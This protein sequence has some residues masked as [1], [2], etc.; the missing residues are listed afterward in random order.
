MPDPLVQLRQG[1]GGVINI[2]HDVDGLPITG[3][4]AAKYQLRDRE[5]NVVLTLTNSAGITW[6]DG[7]IVITITKDQCKTLAGIY[8]HEC[9]AV[10]L[11]G[12]DLTVLEGPI[13]F[14]PRKTWSEL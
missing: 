12:R 1:T 11:A 9:A 13:N 8:E 6:L 14:K 7:H 3:I 4:T 5:G 10:D 2:Q